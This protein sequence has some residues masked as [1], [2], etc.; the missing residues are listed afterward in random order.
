VVLVAWIVLSACQ[1][2]AYSVRERRIR[3]TQPTLRLILAVAVVEL[4]LLL[5]WGAF[6]RPR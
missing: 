2:C 4:V 1:T 5:V 6:L 3:L